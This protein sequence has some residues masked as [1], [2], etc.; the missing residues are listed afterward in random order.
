VVSTGGLP[1]AKH[2]HPIKEEVR[3][4][5]SV[6]DGADMAREHVTSSTRAGVAR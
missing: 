4:L 1:G 3:S 2:S 5:M 6:R